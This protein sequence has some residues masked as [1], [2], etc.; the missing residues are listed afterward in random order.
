VQELPARIHV[1][2]KAKACGAVTLN[3]FIRAEVICT[4]D[5]SKITHSVRERRN[6]LSD[7]Y[8]AMCMIRTAQN[9]HNHRARLFDIW[10]NHRV[11]FSRLAAGGRRREVA[12]SSLSMVRL[13]LQTC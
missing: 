10:K 2:A 6:L 7:F 5:A 1:N 4:V 12:G 13:R 8:S 11:M 9:T 3:V